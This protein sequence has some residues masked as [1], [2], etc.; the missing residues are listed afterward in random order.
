MWISGEYILSRGNFTL[1][2][3]IL[4]ASL[5]RLK[6]LWY[7]TVPY[8]DHLNLFLFYV[9]KRFTLGIKYNSVYEFS[10]LNSCFITNAS[11]ED[12]FFLKSRQRF[13]NCI[14][15]MMS[16]DKSFEDCWIQFPNVFWHFP[17]VLKY[18]SCH[19]QNIFEP[20]FL[21]MLPILPHPF[22]KS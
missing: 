15:N 17:W 16:I 21:T 2:S 1:W 5:K 13:V 11:F 6:R 22:T 4:H 12:G 14:N 20:G 7:V 3:I 18:N 8:T 10:F 9:N 19:Q